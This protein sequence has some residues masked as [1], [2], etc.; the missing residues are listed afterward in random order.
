MKLSTLIKKEE[1]RGSTIVGCWEAWDEHRWLNE[2]HSEHR[3][4][5]YHP[6]QLAGCPALLF[7]DMEGFPLPSEPYSAK[8]ERIFQNGDSVHERIQIQLC[9]AGILDVSGFDD[10]METPI[11]YPALNIGGHTDGVLNF[12]PRHD[13]GMT[14]T[15]FGVEVP[16]FDFEDE[17]QREI[18]EIK[19]I[20][21]RGFKEVCKYGPKEDHKLQA[22]IYCKCL[23][24]QA[25]RFLYENKNDQTWFEKRI[26]FNQK[27]WKSVKDKI[28]LI[29]KWRAEYRETGL[30]PKGVFDAA[31]DS[32]KKRKPWGIYA[33]DLLKPTI[34]RKTIVE[35]KAELDEKL[36][37]EKKKVKIKNNKL[38]PRKKGV[39][40]A[41]K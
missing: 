9:K 38:K 24:I 37:A 7:L 17:N 22:T 31:A 36:A 40:R 23:G 21:D 34:G 26:P 5:R 13:T 6:S 12:G 3:D 2:D 14:I 15:M 41:K 32:G 20:N 11:A 19:S 33:I 8:R 25:T 27:I 29:E 10:S 16:V 4:G 28:L 30:I 35:L 39:R 1:D 18:L